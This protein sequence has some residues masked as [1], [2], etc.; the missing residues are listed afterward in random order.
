MLW[1][2]NG[3]YCGTDRVTH[4]DAD[5]VAH[6]RAHSRPDDIV[7]TD[8]IAH[9]Y[10]DT[11]AYPDSNCSTF[12]VADHGTKCSTYGCAICGSV[13]CTDSISHN[14]PHYYAI[15][16]AHSH[17]HGHAVRGTYP[18]AFCVAD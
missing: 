3:T 17:A 4:C 11:S 16:I 6:A 7:C 10:T 12:C 14:N 1:C 9:S 2:Y 15:D 18:D 8:P 5:S 13:S